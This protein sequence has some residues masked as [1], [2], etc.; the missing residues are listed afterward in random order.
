MYCELYDAKE[1]VLLL[2]Y[3]G[4]AAEGFPIGVDFSIAFNKVI[5]GVSDGQP[6]S[7]KLTYFR[8]S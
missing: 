7:C 2:L 4:G 6:S 1:K 5:S 8:E 3:V